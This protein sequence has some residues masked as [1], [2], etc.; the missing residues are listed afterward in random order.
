MLSGETSVGKY[1]VETVRTMS[2]IAENAEQHHP[3]RPP[4]CNPSGVPE[5]ECRRRHE[6]AGNLARNLLYLR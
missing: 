3:L 6:D 1:P 5:H 2:R 4:P